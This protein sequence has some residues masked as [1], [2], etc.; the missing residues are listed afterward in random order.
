MVLAMDTLA[1]VVGTLALGG[2]QCGLDQHADTGANVRTG[3]DDKGFQVQGPPK[4]LTR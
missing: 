1:L 3:R 4:S 2:T